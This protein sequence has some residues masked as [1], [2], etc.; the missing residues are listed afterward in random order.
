MAYSPDPKVR[1][2]GTQLL[3]MH[4]D[5][6]KMREQQKFQA[7]ENEKSRAAELRAAQIR[8]ASG[9]SRGGSSSGG[10]IKMSTDQYRASLLQR[11]EQ[12]RAAGDQQSYDY[13]EQQLDF[14]NNITAQDRP[15][16]LAG[17]PDTGAL[18]IP[19][20]APRP[21][22]VAPPL[23]TTGGTPPQAPKQQTFSVPASAAQ[24]LKQNPGLAAQFDA[25]YGAGAA[26][27]ILG[28]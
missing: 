5:F 12:A 21:K 2:Q 28:K 25:K 13:F 4:K 20:N 3:K 8:A 16:P 17:K 7:A 1:E 27:F 10:H 18:G 14:V 19:T 9:G 22:P 6:V 23:P 15:D 11:M 24:Y 26:K